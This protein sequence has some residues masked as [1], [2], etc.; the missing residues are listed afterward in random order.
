[1]KALAGL[2]TVLLAVMTTACYRQTAVSSGD[3]NYFSA[4]MSP[5]DT[6]W[7]Y[8]ELAVF[9]PDTLRDSV[10]TG[11]TLLLSVRHTNSYP[12]RN[13]WLELAYPADDSTI[14]ADTVNIVLADVYGN[15]TGK[16]M[17]VSHQLTD[18]V[19]TDFRLVRKKPVTVRH[20]MRTDTLEGIEQIGI[21]YLPAQ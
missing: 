5:E 4:F 6:K 12:Y 14:V 8:D 3:E 1:M 11:G 16:G 17:G 19:S 21:I 2:L 15:W 20:I 10:A 7:L 9:R 18:T 13:L